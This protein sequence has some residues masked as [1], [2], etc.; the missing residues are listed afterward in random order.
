MV[1]LSIFNT[2]SFVQIHDNYYENERFFFNF[3]LFSGIYEAKAN[4]YS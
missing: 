1:E 4:A 2:N 3:L